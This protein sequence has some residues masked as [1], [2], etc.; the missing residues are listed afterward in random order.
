MSFSAR[1]ACP[2]LCLSLVIFLFFFRLGHREL[3]S[4]HERGR[5][6]T[7]SGCSIPASGGCQCSSTGRQDF[8]SRRVI[9]GW[10]RRLVGSTAKVNAW[11]ARLPAAL[12]G[13]L[14]VAMVFAFL[15]SEERP[16]AARSPPSRWRRRFTSQRSAALPASTCRSPAAMTVSLLAFAKCWHHRAKPHGFFFRPLPPLAA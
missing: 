1:A 8:R 2:A 7:P 3:Y 15:R 13:L 16:V 11:V 9:T 10:S 5:P 6:R 4:S 14:V 12:A